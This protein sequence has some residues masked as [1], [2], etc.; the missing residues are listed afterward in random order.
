MELDWGM[1]R[2]IKQWNLLDRRNR[3][4]SYHRT[5]ADGMKGTD[6]KWSLGGLLDEVEEKYFRILLA[7]KCTGRW[8]KRGGRRRRWWGDVKMEVVGEG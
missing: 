1:T 4:L 3:A 2:I 5:G 7:R 6:E 8:V